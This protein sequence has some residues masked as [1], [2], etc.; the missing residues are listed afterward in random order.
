M[1]TN[2]LSISKLN[3][4]LI[5]LA[6]AIA[7]GIVLFYF[8]RSFSGDAQATQSPTIPDLIATDG[9]LIQFNKKGTMAY[10][11]FSQKSEHYKQQN[12]TDFTK[13]IG[14]YYS[15]KHQPWKVTADKGRALHGTE[16]IHLSGNV[17]LQQRAGVNNKETTLTTTQVT[18]YPQKDMAEND[19][20]THAKQPGIAVSSIGFRAN[21][22]EGKVVLLSQ[23]QGNYINR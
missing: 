12:R 1:A 22:K 21:F 18:I 10:Q 5:Y 14:Y 19:V 6:V 23:A 3:K 15:E 16:E 8:Y 20:L 9:H 2:M 4:Q 17:H 7:A 13:P 11:F